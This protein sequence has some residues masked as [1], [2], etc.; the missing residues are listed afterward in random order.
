M[1]HSSNHFF[2]SGYYESDIFINHIPQILF[3]GI[4]A[5]CTISFDSSGN[6]VTVYSEFK[7]YIFSCGVKPILM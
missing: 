4:A 2:L 1:F 6:I 5:K 3:K 7:S